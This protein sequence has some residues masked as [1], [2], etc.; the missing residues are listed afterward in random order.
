MTFRRRALVVAAA[1][2]AL[3]LAA[4]TPPP[5]PGGALDGLRGRYAA[6]RDRR[7]AL[8][9]A[10]TADLV[11]RVDG[12]ATGR[13]PALPTTLALAAPGRVRLQASGLIGVALDLLVR[14]DSLWAWVPSERV[15]FRAAS[16]SL[17]VGDP[18]ALAGRVLGATWDPPAAAWRAAASDSAGWRLA[19]REGADSLALVVDADAR[20]REAWLGREGRGVRARYEDWS[21]VRG[22]A[23]PARCELA[24]DTGWARVRVRIDEVTAAEQPDSAWFTPRRRGD[25]RWL[26]WDDLKSLLERGGV[27]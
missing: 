5:R 7:E 11:V 21:R 23:F 9:H 26:G 8:L 27:R 25:V 15:A 24:D 6:A 1:L 3:T 22:E 4:C 14:R 17:G 18:A 19:W 12:R 16:E 2:A 13:L 10:L 20:P